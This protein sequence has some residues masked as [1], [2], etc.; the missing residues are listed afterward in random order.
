MCEGILMM[1]ST[2]ELL[3]LENTIKNVM[4]SYRYIHTIGVRD[5]A[6]KIARY[7]YEG[8]ISELVAAALLHDISKEYSVEKQLDIMQKMN[9]NLT[10]SDFMSKQIFHAFTA[11]YVIKNEYKIFSTENIL[12]AVLNHTTG[13]PNMSLFDE[14][15]FIADYVEDNRKHLNCVNV[16]EKLY[17][18]FN[19]SRDREECV[20]HLHKATMS[21]L[22]LTI[23]DLLKNG[24]CLNERTVST[25][26]A[27]LSRVPMPIN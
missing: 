4:S 8:D 6:K 12:S 3:E 22:E 14:I 5:A 10:D 26:N 27:F 13:N 7:C 20:A 9:I 19:S 15:I 25:R 16:R 21:V 2:E 11:P 1:F 17:G 23:I 24:K 18:A